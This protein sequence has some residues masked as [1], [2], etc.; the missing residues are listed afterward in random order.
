MCILHGDLTCLQGQALKGKLSFFRVEW[1]QQYLYLTV[2]NDM[3]AVT[4]GYFVYFLCSVWFGLVHFCIYSRYYLEHSWQVT[5]VTKTSVLLKVVQKKSGSSCSALYGWC[6]TGSM[7]MR[8]YTDGSAVILC[9][10]YYTGNWLGR[11]TV[12]FEQGLQLMSMFIIC[13]ST[14]CQI[15][16]KNCCSNYP[17]SKKTYLKVCCAGFSLKMTMYTLNNHSQI[18]T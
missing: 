13:W 15:I 7:Q 6:N 16:M 8:Q 10:S 9:N 5:L 3:L 18:I 2:D 1:M 14:K 17:H 4:V 12:F 11:S